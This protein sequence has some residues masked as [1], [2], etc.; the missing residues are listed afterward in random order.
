MS[1]T[2]TIKFTLKWVMTA[3]G[4]MVPLFGL[5]LWAFQ[6]YLIYVPS[7]PPGSRETTWLPSRFGMQ[8]FD[9][10]KLKTKDGLSL[11]AFWIPSQKSSK[12]TPTIIY[13]HANAGNMGHRLPISKIF[14]QLFPCNILMFSYRGYGTSDGHPNEEGLKIDAQTALD[15]VQEKT[16]DE[17]IVLYGQSLGGAVAIDLAAKNYDSIHALIVENTF[18]NIPAMIPSILPKFIQNLDF[19]CHQ[20]WHNDLQIRKLVVDNNKLPMPILFLSGSQDNLV[21]PCQMQR[22]YELSITPGSDNT[23]MKDNLLMRRRFHS[24]KDGAHNDTYLQSGYFDHIKGFW[25]DFVSP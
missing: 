15:W 4:V 22:L 18:L 11:D 5:L 2:D 20:R 12:V 23:E 10:V 1:I 21:D 17:P 16:P 8:K 25:N 7:M 14:H 19:L 24:L 9:R 6:G 13:C 3:T